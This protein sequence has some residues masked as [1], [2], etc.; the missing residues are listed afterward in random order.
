MSFVYFLFKDNSFP[1]IKYDLSELCNRKA[2]T[3]MRHQY[4][5]GQ[6]LILEGRL[7][8]PWMRKAPL[9]RENPQKDLFECLVIFLHEYFHRNIDYI[10]YIVY[11]LLVIL[12]QYFPK[13]IHLNGQKSL[14]VP[15][16]LKDKTQPKSENFDLISLHWVEKIFL[17]HISFDK[18]LF[19]INSHHFNWIHWFACCFSS[20]FS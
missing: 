13:N 10:F 19:S 7:R 12:I 11:I 15:T 6:F 17:L 1:I 9:P 3:I 5:H 4:G 20:I 18:L 8:F 16:H 14:N 2:V